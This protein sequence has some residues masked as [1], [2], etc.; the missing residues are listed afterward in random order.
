MFFNRRQPQTKHT[1]ILA[2]L[3]FALLS[4]FTWQLASAQ[5]DEALSA[6]ETV[7]QAWQLAQKSG[8][9]EFRTQVKQTTYPLPK[10]TSAGKQPTVQ[11]M[12]IEGEV[13]FRDEQ[14][15]LTFW[16]DLSF[17]PETG[18]EV[19]VE[20]GTAYG[21]QGGGEWEALDNNITDLFAPGGDPMQ[22][23]V[24]LKNVTVGDSR[25][26][27][28]GVATVE[29]Q[30]Y[31][32][33]LDGVVFAEHM[34]EL[35]EQK[36]LEKGK[37]PPGVKLSASDAYKRM[38]GSGELWLNER[39]LPIQLVY[40][41]EFPAQGEE[42]R[43]TAVI[44]SNFFQYDLDYLD[45][46]TI[47]FLQ[48]PP[49]WV[50]VH[51]SPQKTLQAIAAIWFFF[52][53]ALLVKVVWRSKQFQRVVALFII[54]S[55]LFSPLLRA[56]SV[57]AFFDEQGAVQERV[58]AEQEEAR[59]TA[60]AQAAL[61]TTTWQPNQTATTQ[62]AA[63]IPANIAP[64]S[65]PD[66]DDDGISDADEVDIWGTDPNN[67]DSDGDGLNDG[68]EAYTLGTAPASAD[69][70]GDQINDNL[71]VGGFTYN[72]EDWYLDP[73]END[74]NVD[75]LT[76]GKE[77][78]NLIADTIF[79]NPTAS[80]P[81]TDN[82]GTPDLFDS[83]NDGDGIED[84]FDLDPNS[85][86]GQIFSK[87]NLFEW[88]VDN[89]Q[90]GRTVFVDFQIRPTNPNNLALH[91][92]VLDWPTGDTQ[93]QIRRTLDTT[94][95]D[96]A[97]L[98]LRSTA[99]N[100][101]NG[102]VR[103]TPVLEIVIPGKVGHYGNLPVV[104]DYSGAGRPAGL[105]AEEWVDMSRL[106]PYNI[107]VGD[108]GDP[109]DAYRDL[110]V[111]APITLQTDADTGMPIAFGARMPYFPIQGTG[112]VADWGNKHQM[113]LAWLVQMISDQ[114]I[115]EDEDPAT[116]SREDVLQVIHVYDEDW[117]LTGLSIS[118][119]HGIDVGIIY[120]DPALD[121]DLNSDDQ[122]WAAANSLNSTLLR[123]RDMNNDGVRDVR[124]DNLATEMP[125]WHDAASGSYYLGYQP[126][127][128]TYADSDQIYQI[129]ITETVSLL[130]TTFSGYE[131]QT[132][133]TLL[134]VRETTNRVV[135]LEMMAAINNS[136]TADFDPDIVRP[137][138]TADMNWKPYEYV[139]GEW[140]NG[141]PEAYLQNL[142]ARLSDLVFVEPANAT[143][144]EIDAI[145][146]QRL[147]AQLYY[148]TLYQGI[149][150][151]VESNGNVIWLTDAAVNESL[152]DPA[153]PNTT[154]T[155]A[156]YVA[157]AF[158]AG[159]GYAIVVTIAN[160]F[161]IAR[162]SQPGLG[163]WSAFKSSFGNTATKSAGRHELFPAGSNSLTGAS[164]TT[165]LI[166][167]TSYFVLAAVVV[168]LALFVNGYFGGNEGHLKWGTRILNAVSL[169]VSIAHFAIVSHALVNLLKL[170]TS[171]AAAAQA[172]AIATYDKFIRGSYASGYAGFIMSLLIAW[173]MF[174]YQWG[175][176]QFGGNKIVRN[177]NIAVAIATT[178]IAI[179]TFLIDVVLKVAVTAAVS[180]FGTLLVLLVAIIDVILYFAGEKTITQRATEAIARATYD[181]DFILSNFNS[182]KRLSFDLTDVILA[183]EALGF[184]QG[185]AFHPVF[186]IDNTIHFR[187]QSNND[188]ARRSAFAYYVQSA[189]TDRHGSLNGNSMGGDWTPING[190]KLQY[191]TT[192]TGTSPITF[193]TVGL[194]KPISALYLTEAFAI[195]Y[196]GCWSVFGAETDD[197]DWAYIKGSNHVD[198]GSELYFDI[199]PATV[200]AF[201]QVTAW[202]G[203]S[204]S[205]PFPEQTDQDNDGLLSQAQGGADPDDTD[206]D[207][208]DDGLSD[209]VEIAK[210]TDPENADSDGDGLN[211]RYEL[212]RWR[213]NPNDPDTD[214]DGL[215][216]GVEVVD[217]WLVPTGIGN[218]VMRVWSNPFYADLDGD[219]LDDLQ[220]FTFGFHP[221]VPTDPSAIANLIQLHGME[222]DELLAPLLYLDFDEVGD[223]FFPAVTSFGG[224]E[225]VATCHTGLDGCPTAV[226]N[227]RYG[228]AATFDGIDDGLEVTLDTELDMHQADFTIGVWLKTTGT[229]GGAIFARH[230]GNG[231][232]ETGEELF[233]LD[234]S[235][236]F[237]F[238]TIGSGSGARGANFAGAS[239]AVFDGEWHH[240]TA[241]WD[242]DEASGSGAGT[243][244]L[245]GVDITTTSSLFDP[246]PED[247]SGHTITIG[248]G[249]FGSPWQGAMDQFTLIPSALSAAQVTDLMMGRMQFNDQI[250]RPS[251]PLRY[252]TNI[253]NT[254][255]AQG[256]NGFV[257]GTSEPITPSIPTP[258]LALHFDA[259]ERLRH[260][261]PNTGNSSTWVCV[262]NGTCPQGGEFDGV[263][264]VIYLPTMNV[265]EEGAID[266]YWDWFAYSMFLRLD[267][268][269]PAGETMTIMETDV[270]LPGSL[271]IYVDSDGWIW[272]DIQD[273]LLKNHNVGATPYGDAATQQA[274][275]NSKVGQHTAH[276]IPVYENGDR[277]GEMVNYV[278][279]YNQGDSPTANNYSRLYVNYSQNSAQ[280][281]QMVYEYRGEAYDGLRVGSGT[282]GQGGN[283]V[284]FDGRLN[285][286]G[287]YNG[288]ITDNALFLSNVSSGSWYGFNLDGSRLN[289]AFVMQPN[290]G[291]ER[292]TAY[293]DDVTGVTGADCAGSV[294]CPATDMGGK[295]GETAVFDGVDDYLW[296]GPS[297]FAQGDYTISGWFNSTASAEQPILVAL[298][299]SSTATISVRLNSSGA[300]V[301]D[302]GYS[303][304]GSPISVQSS[305]GYND[306]AWHH[307]SAVRA[308]TDSTLY[309]DGSVAATASGGDPATEIVN[310]QIGRLDTDHYAGK[311]DDLLIIPA[312]LEEDAI[313]MTMNSVWPTIDIADD[314]VPFHL[315]ANASATVS[316]EASVNATALNSSHLFEQEAEVAVEL[317]EVINLPIVDPISANL[318]IHAPFEEVP[319]A[320]LFENIAGANEYV[321][322]IAAACPMAGLRG[323]GDRAAFFDGEDDYL[324][325]SDSGDLLS[326]AAWVRADRGVI[327]DTRESHPYKGVEL[328]FSLLRVQTTNEADD[329]YADNIAT[330]PLDLPERRWTHLVVTVNTNNHTV[331]VYVNGAFH[332]SVSYLG[333]G[334][335]I[336]NSPTLGGSTK[337]GNYLNGYLADFRAYDT[338][339]T[340]A[341]VTALYESSAPV[342]RF[343]FDETAEDVVFSDLSTNGFVGYPTVNSSFNTTLN[344]TVTL[345]NPTPG[346]DGKIGNTALFVAG[347]GLTVDPANDAPLDLNEMTIMLWVNPED[348]STTTQ[349]LLVKNNSG[350][351]ERNYQLSLQPNSLQ[352]SFG[353]H[354][355]DCATGLG[356]L[357]SVGELPS[358][359]WTHV[360]LTFDGNAANIYFNG[361]LDSSQS[362]GGVSLCQND[363]PL[364]IGS[365]F[366]GELDELAIYGRSMSA[367]ELYSIYLR[368]LRWYRARSSSLLRIDNDK[369]TV[370]LA[371]TYPYRPLGY[372][373]LVVSASDPS[374]SVA[375]LDFGLKAPGES[376]FSWHGATECAESEGGAA[377]CPAFDSASL[378][379]AGVYEVQFRAVDAVGFE[380]VSSVYEIIVDDTPPT[381]GSNYSGD[382]IT[383]VPDPTQVKSWVG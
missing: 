199:L 167:L 206:I 373:Q 73:L 368:E 144:E 55:M 257:I 244:Y 264:D 195:P 110:V 370:G 276:G 191:T 236:N 193:T 250:V 211:D 153:W 192:I 21:R 292:R 202:N 62:L 107:T 371:S 184:T 24:G 295:Y 316:G 27:D 337:G 255:L 149:N 196:Q 333:F 116:C 52:V 322:P 93:G 245:D 180:A 178:A 305:N 325:I 284:A 324:R 148:A 28:L 97:N 241:V 355:D 279:V 290:N 104:A 23:L 127:I 57:T 217:G 328:D 272:F 207:T 252:S 345:L 160:H 105:A 251:D 7:A 261:L 147:W 336:L 11:N 1:L 51:V 81:D 239:T 356:E 152:Y 41:L 358:N 330:L 113:R 79:Y 343:E 260:Y 335:P 242:Y 365:E 29:G 47:P 308:G 102:D 310:V 301:F 265:R 4:L 302:H 136:F 39:G 327:F 363:H 351:A 150:N 329:E 213:T 286:V 372:T 197:C 201:A 312:A 171:G 80:C 226:A 146:G 246:L 166:D 74:T 334:D 289:P 88:G 138:V 82:D 317:Q 349:N 99:D 352:V 253:T 131:T 75:G 179:A 306:G 92:N 380:T 95:A 140:T 187:K 270:D 85:H 339:L 271:D 314:F 163:F 91:G 106:E 3:F 227:G 96:T 78:P 309:I 238:L 298:D 274:Y 70:D 367:E 145:E 142:D 313:Q 2:F 188:E 357:T 381:V 319:G 139:A 30:Q 13:D 33:E 67:V 64:N 181:V 108:S 100:A 37:L 216:D 8:R 5:A 342:L 154:F 247:A 263:D 143:Q 190:R 369:P 120:E 321:C 189:E 281:H 297:D 360:A 218:G 87:D 200:A 94:F 254:L 194:N 340:A 266:F 214:D 169:A 344:E 31:R 112:G 69:T 151:I 307:F 132:D 25:Q 46:A 259:D 45:Q 43:T 141:D 63:N 249:Q 198:T 32:F 159:L 14:L 50:S 347:D 225:A 359:Q 17:N 237:Q 86:G 318:K 204:A 176:G 277:L 285:S 126:F 61:Q 282:F 66:S 323:L 326:F 34:R 205:L 375:L 212:I 183:D 275:Y 311:V 293:L 299:P 40:D 84:K 209:A 182:A 303:N 229:N 59:K 129:M 203:G 233:F 300:V 232:W 315:N 18:V 256:A 231:T 177:F 119:E 346:T 288:D 377:W 38:I 341:Q 83:D 280:F 58:Q 155:G 65:D 361:L 273:T 278:F 9:Y 16:G 68:L 121:S 134:F 364:R 287:A 164:F 71:E 22:F 174:L 185:N 366:A 111:Y 296:A 348:A 89:L 101:A 133:P 125:S 60:V 350:T 304:S 378:S 235:G 90:T 374:S 12:G 215:S 332:D 222:V 10:I 49:T 6:E 269:P 283:G 54:V 170:V 262:D 130:N 109:N 382:T 338:T 128:N 158:A 223:G 114:C 210:G 42:E 72:S 165:H 98:A 77:C 267:S 320:T 156:S 228:A 230:D 294:E 44:T 291:L 53:A 268:L 376:T 331:T 234:A 221:M 258:D 135:S 354:L 15:N 224:A 35:M 124:V 162:F 36:L 26:L 56:E 353:A 175:A 168:G 123:G 118:E 137:T 220:E 157:Q 117:L 173:G 383:A 186:D 243:I 76:D 208:D 48:S 122:L 19:L 161:N 103:L 379:G 240:I 362:Y 115:N 172:A 248:T 20:D 219:Q